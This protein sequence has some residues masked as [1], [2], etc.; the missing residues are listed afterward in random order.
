MKLKEL[1]LKTSENETISSYSKKPPTKKTESS[2]TNDKKLDNFD[3][4]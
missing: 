4:Y 2:K 3:N 1:I